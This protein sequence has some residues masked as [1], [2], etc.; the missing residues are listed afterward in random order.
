MPDYAFDLIHL[1][2]FGLA[3]GSLLA[4][5]MSGCA[6][7][8]Q[9]HGDG[10]VTRSFAFGAPVIIPMDPDGQ[11]NITNVTGFGLSMSN[12]AA[13]LGWLNESK[14]ALDRDCRLVLVGNTTEQIQQV[15][16]LFGNTKGLCA[17]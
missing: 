4:M 6:I 16:R 14:I 1:K 7:V 9:I 15:A 17:D 13:T 8:D 3:L 10:T 2:V 12:G 11:A 5:A